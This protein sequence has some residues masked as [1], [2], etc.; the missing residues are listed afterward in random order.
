LLTL[1]DLDR[2][3]RAAQHAR[4]IR[5]QITKD[6]G[7]HDHLSTLQLI[8]A[9]TTAVLAC[10]LADL[11]IRW[12][13]GEPVDPTTVATIVNTFNRSASMLGL[14]RQ[15][16]D[17]APSLSQYLDSVRLPHPMATES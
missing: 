2:R 10:Q 1:D 3:T 7:G 16:R 15:A 9:D 14:D 6:L 5:D 11:K 12:L 4:Q 8:V 13:K 17:V